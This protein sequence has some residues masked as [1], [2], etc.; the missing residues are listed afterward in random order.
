MSIDEQDELE[1]PYECPD[2]GEGHDGTVTG[3]EKCPSCEHDTDDDED[4]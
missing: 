4:E 3:T 2:C 1:Y